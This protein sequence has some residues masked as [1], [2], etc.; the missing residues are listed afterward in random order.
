[1]ITPDLRDNPT[2]RACGT[3]R[4]IH[5]TRAMLRGLDPAGEVGPE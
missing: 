5:A 4:K 1:M 2:C 3:L